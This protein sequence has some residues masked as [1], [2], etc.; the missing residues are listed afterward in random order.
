MARGLV[1]SSIAAFLAA[2]ALSGHLTGGGPTDYKK[3]ETKRATG[4][5][6]YSLKLGD[7]YYSYHRFE[8]VGLAAGLIADSV[9]GAMHGDSEVVSQ[10]KADSAV[11]HIMRNLDSMAFMGTLANLLQAVHD[12]VGGRAQSFISREAGS[13]IPAGIANIAEGADRTIRRP[14]SAIQAIESRIPGLTS[15]A[16]PIVDI[17]GH[18]VQRPASNLGGAWPFEWTS[19]KH[20]PV[21]DEMSRLGLS[22]PQPPKTIKWKGKPTQ[23]TDSERQQFAQQEGQEFVKRV[24]RVMQGGAWQRRTDDAKRKALVQLHDMIN[25]SRPARL[26]RIRKQSQALLARDSL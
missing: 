14:Q 17:T 24:G 8:P 1:G 4:W 6:P 19:D 11:K 9:H 12:P 20:D 21:L 15:A 13:L 25:Q 26:S 3:E 2:L 5:Q 7:K 16:P 10:S 23:L 18:L 22:T